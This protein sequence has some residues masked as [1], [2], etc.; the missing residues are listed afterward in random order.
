LP[1]LVDVVL[2]GYLPA[3]PRQVAEHLAAYVSKGIGGGICRPPCSDAGCCHVYL[4]CPPPRACRSGHVFAIGVPGTKAR[5][6]RRLG[7]RS[8]GGGVYVVFREGSPWERAYFRI[9][10]GGVTELPPPCPRPLLEELRE[11][12]GDNGLRLREAVDVLAARLGGRGEARRVIEGLVK[13]LCLY[14][15]EGRVY[16]PED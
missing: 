13:R 2:G 14:V 15:A 4:Y 1:R 6:L 7:L 3:A 5:G 16:V 11:H 12:A 9:D 8:L 10:V